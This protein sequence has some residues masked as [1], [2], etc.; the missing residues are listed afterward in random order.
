MVSLDHINMS[1]NNLPESLYWYKNVFNFEVVEQ[2]EHKG[3]PYAIIKS[4]ESM[5]CLYEL[6]DKISPA[7]NTNHK[8]YHFGL[9]VRDMDQWEKKISEQ[10]L[11]INLQWNYPHSKAWYLSDPTGHEIEV[12]YWNDDKIKF[13]STVP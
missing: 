3:L 7:E 5:L 9:R 11:S 8:V 1:V 13:N 12:T 6:K 4:N 10:K 2:G